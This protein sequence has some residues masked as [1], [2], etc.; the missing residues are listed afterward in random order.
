M[1]PFRN[2]T[3]RVHS[4]R[5]SGRLSRLKE[6]FSVKGGEILF[7]TGFIPLLWILLWK[8][9]AFPQND[10]LEFLAMGFF[11]LCIAAKMVLYDRWK[12]WEV[13][14]FAVCLVIAGLSYYK[15]TFTRPLVFILCVFGA[16]GLDGR[17][18]LKVWLVLSLLNLVLAVSASILGIV[19]NYSFDWVADEET[20][21]DTKNSLGM[22]H[23]TDCAARFFF[24]VLVAI[25]LRGERFGWWDALAVCG[26]ALLTY[27]YTG[28]RIDS[29][30][31]AITAGLFL[32]QNLARKYGKPRNPYTAYEPGG[33]ILRT[34]ALV[35]FPCFASLSFFLCTVYQKGGALEKINKW[36]SQRLSLGHRT[37]VDYDVKLF[38]QY[39]KM[40]GNGNG[41]DFLL[42]DGAKY[43]FIDISYQSVLI[44]YGAVFF[45]V[46]MILYMALA[47]T[48]R[49]DLYL[50]ICIIMITFNCMFAHHL[51]EIAY[52]PFILLLF[53]SQSDLNIGRNQLGEQRESE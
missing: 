40:Y 47:R 12:R 16:K 28:G 23:T 19:E 52:I 7:Y 8:T 20:I 5:V 29:G 22:I 14:A 18:I 44:L 48:R 33:K 13:V 15:S 31:M 10:R 42:I 3:A 6:E 37:F 35:S 41:S 21:S 26:L 2:Q 24:T 30:C 43:N 53:C 9:T 38:G 32:I 45:A 11:A 51:T 25:Y 17:K 49:K 39:I 50:M 27:Y 36:S 46:V 34:G 1:Q 4:G